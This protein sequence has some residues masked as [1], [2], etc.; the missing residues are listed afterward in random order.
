MKL[1]QFR[2]RFAILLAALLLPCF[3]LTAFAYEAVDT[4]R[5]AS[6]TVYFGDGENGYRCGIPGLQGGRCI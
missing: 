3:A 5:E 6:L 4:G 1:H 2:K